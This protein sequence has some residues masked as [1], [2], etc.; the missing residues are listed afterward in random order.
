MKIKHFIIL[1][2]VFIVTTV[3]SATYIYFSLDKEEIYTPIEIASPPNNISEPETEVDINSNDTTEFELVEI[4]TKDKPLKFIMPVNSNEFGMKFSD[5]QLIYSKTLNEW[6]T[7]NGI[8]I[9]EKVGTPVFAIEDGTIKEIISTPDEGI[10]IIIEHRDGYKSVYSNLSTTKMVELNDEIKKGE[11]ISG[12][13]KTAAFEYQEPDHLH[14]EM[15][16]DGLLINP[17]NVI[18]P[19]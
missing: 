1:I 9:L 14:F 10:K 3:A 16:K 11:V 13:G 8:D 4:E 2:S 15:Y 6:R 19:E 7:H 5:G 18:T 12:I 17:L